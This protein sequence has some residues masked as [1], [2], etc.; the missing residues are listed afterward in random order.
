MNEVTSRPQRKAQ[1]FTLLP[2][3]NVLFALTQHTHFH[4]SLSHVHCQQMHKRPKMGC[5][6][7]NT[8]KS[9]PS[10]SRDMSLIFLKIQTVPITHVHVNP[11]D[12]GT[13]AGKQT[14]SPTACGLWEQFPWWMTQKKLQ[15]KNLLFA[16]LRTHSWKSLI[17]HGTRSWHGCGLRLKDTET[18][19][20]RLPGQPAHKA[21]YHRLLLPKGGNKQTN[22]QRQRNVCGTT[23]LQLVWVQSHLI[24]ES[25]P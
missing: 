5:H 8:S 21:M 7:I 4:V 6:V 1:R 20:Y 11:R 22:K 16:E 17:K 12:E 9:S 3:L 10:H 15:N 19:L 25:S 24:L 13:C 2:C 18:C 23:I 14:A